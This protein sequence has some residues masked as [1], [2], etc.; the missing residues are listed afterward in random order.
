MQHLFGKFQNF[1]DAHEITDRFQWRRDVL[2]KAMM[3]C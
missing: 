1:F 3:G 2:C